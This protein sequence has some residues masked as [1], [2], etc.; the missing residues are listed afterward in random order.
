EEVVSKKHF[1]DLLVHA[2][3]RIFYA[4]RGGL[5]VGMPTGIHAPVFRDHLKIA[6]DVGSTTILP[7]VWRSCGGLVRGESISP[8]YTSAPEAASKDPTLYEILA[9]IDVV[10]IGDTRSRNIAVSMLEKRVLGR[11][12]DRTPD[13]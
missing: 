8:L 7:T 3:P 11:T 6:K 13:L 9:L 12:A 4:V 10:R 5:E 1:C 2:V